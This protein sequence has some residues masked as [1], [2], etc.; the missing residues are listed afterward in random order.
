MSLR[1]ALISLGLLLLIAATVSALSVK[2]SFDSASVYY[3][4]EAKVFIWVV[5]DKPYD[6]YVSFS[7]QF[8]QQYPYGYDLTGYFEDPHLVAEPLGAKGT[9][10][11]ITPARNVRGSEYVTIT[12]R[13]CNADASVCETASKQLLVIL[14]PVGYNYYL[15]STAHGPWYVP[16]KPTGDGSPLASSVMFAEYFYPTNYA[17]DFLG[18]FVCKELAPGDVA[19]LKTTLFNKGV[20]GS[21]DMHLIGD[22]YALNAVMAQ[23]RVS[24]PTNGLQELF[25][26][27]APS[28]N[29]GAGRYWVTVQA[30]HNNIVLAEKDLCVDVVDRYEARLVLPKTIRV[31][32]CGVV[33]V[34]A[35]I[36]NK[37]T[38]A[39]TYALESDVG[40]VTPS[41]VTVEAGR[42]Q[43][44][45]IIIDG[46]RLELGVTPLVVT[47]NSL[48]GIDVAPFKAGSLVEVI[49]CPPAPP[50]GEVRVNKSESEDLIKLVVM[51]ENPAAEP[52]KNVSIEVSGLP[53]RWEVTGEK[54]VVIPPK[55][56]RPITLF[57]RRT[58]DEEAKGVVVT[59]KSGDEVIAVKEIPKIEAHATGLTG[60][61]T[62]ALSQNL[63]F[64][65]LIILI[66]LL[67]VVLA[68][69]RKMERELKELKESREVKKVKESKKLIRKPL[70]GEELEVGE[71][72]RIDA[73]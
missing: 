32:N 48:Q 58:T 47:A 40:E 2:T 15:N 21:F 33:Q 72:A 66:A 64:I 65:A 30:L 61:F 54:N 55:T 69:R 70:K 56:T 12:A 31:S 59:V 10:F 39:D 19:R 3:G 9:Y 16:A 18:G 38:R 29:L 68:G 23:E 34:T 25:V 37:G 57:I 1:E 22:R 20:A 49:P 71:G 5:S 8:Q 13:A 14:Y 7:A 45:K 17:V 11:R 35:K 26:D 27:V 46:T 51:V 67:I 43:A 44:F 4:R 36:I 42:E 6:L 24:L 28:R 53:T 52:L 73:E 50:A 63:W 62:L 60:F 41:E